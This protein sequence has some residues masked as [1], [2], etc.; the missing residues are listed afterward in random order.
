MNSGRGRRAGCPRHCDGN[1][2]V[3]GTDVDDGVDDEEGFPVF[4][5]EDVLVVQIFNEEIELRKVVIVVFVAEGTEVVTHPDF[6]FIATGTAS[7]V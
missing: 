1:G 4:G 5:H 3:G 7:T 2:N 6:H